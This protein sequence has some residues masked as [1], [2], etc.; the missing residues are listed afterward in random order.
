MENLVEEIITVVTEKY[1]FDYR[2]KIKNIKHFLDF[3]LV[4]N[5]MEGS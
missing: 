4:G 3:R 1:E 5:I 2:N